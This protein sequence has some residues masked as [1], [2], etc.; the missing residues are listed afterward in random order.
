MTSVT[1]ERLP[2]NEHAASIDRQLG[3]EP[4]QRPATKTEGDP[5]SLQQF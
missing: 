4:G 1:T 5:K 3:P 2:H